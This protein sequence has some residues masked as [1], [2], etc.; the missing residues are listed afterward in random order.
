MSAP[1]NLTIEFGYGK[2]T[3]KAYVIGFA[4]CLLLTVSAFYCIAKHIFSTEN[5]YISLTALAIAQL[6][7]QSICFLR[8]NSRTEG[9][10]NLFPFLFVVLIIAI[11][12]GGSLWIMYNLNY[13]MMN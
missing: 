13:N 1:E 7:I 9:R 3:L 6:L 12:T 2:K 10:W 11:L 5:L 8:L 4:L